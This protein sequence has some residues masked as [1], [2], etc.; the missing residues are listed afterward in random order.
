E[1]ELF[2]KERLWPEALIQL[3]PAYALGASVG[4]LCNQGKLHPACADIFCDDRGRP[5]TLYYHQ[6]AAIE[7]ALRRE[8]YVV[9]SG[10]GSGKTLTYFI[11][12]FDAVLKSNPAEA[13]V[14]AIIVY[15]M[16]ALVNS[17][18]NALDELKQRY[19]RRTGQ[20]L[21]VRFAKYTGQEGETERN[22]ILE[23]PPHILLTNYMMLELILVRPRERRFV[24]RAVAGIEFLVFDE[25]HT[26][27]GR[28]G[29]DVALLIRRLRQRCG[30]P[31]L[32]CIGTS[33]TMVSDEQMGTGE[34]RR[35][36][37]DFASKIF[38]TAVPPENVIEERFRPL[39]PLADVDPQ[40]LR[41][42]VENPLPDT[43]E[44]LRKHPLTWWIERH[45]GFRTAADATS[46][47][48]PPL[49]L[50]EAA[51]R[52]ARETGLEETQCREALRAA[53]LLGTRL[54]E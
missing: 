8:P 4:D 34:R 18:H 2:A 36:V 33:A 1:Q 29:A 43:A 6:E 11:P 3:N 52:L 54:R 32:I 24:D 15:P 21:P 12:I 50:S 48:C 14:R 42:A 40:A 25:L 28:Q 16:N 9:T 49:T 53:L 22:A 35:A 31:N 41:A 23:S 13:R 38:G 5:F 45:L 47:R 19:Q 10:T 44:E 37:A 39:S 17:Q 46:E 7:C 26:Y 51:K 20:P 30:N 27:R